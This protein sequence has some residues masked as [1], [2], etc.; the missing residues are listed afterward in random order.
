M[1]K[2]ANVPNFFL[3]FLPD[4]TLT[5]RVA[6][7]ESTLFA[8]KKKKL[9]FLLQQVVDQNFFQRKERKKEKKN[10]TKIIAQA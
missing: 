5:E 10:I 9:S 2:K 6:S 8:Q 1:P 3:L 7:F 4:G